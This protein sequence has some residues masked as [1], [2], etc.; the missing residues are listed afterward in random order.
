MRSDDY[1]MADFV[2]GSQAIKEARD[3]NGVELKAGDYISL[4]KES[5]SGGEIKTIL[6]NGNITVKIKNKIIQLK[7]CDC[8]KT[9]KSAYQYVPMTDIYSKLVIKE[10][11]TALLVTDFTPEYLTGLDEIEKEIKRLKELMPALTESDYKKFAALPLNKRRYIFDTLIAEQAKLTPKAKTLRELRQ[12]LEEHGG[13]NPSDADSNL[14]KPTLFLDFTTG[15]INGDNTRIGPVPT[16][17]RSTSASYVNSQGIIS[18]ANIN[19]PRFNYDPVTLKPQGLLVE[20]GRT[21]L[22][23]W[24]STISQWTATNSTFTSTTTA[25]PNGTTTGSLTAGLWARTALTP[26]LAYAGLAPATVTGN[27]AYTGSIYVQPVSGDYFAL[28]LQTSGGGTCQADVVFNLSTGSISTQPSNNTGNMTNLGASIVPAGNGW[29]RV[30]LAATM[31]AG[32]TSCQ[33]LFTFNATGNKTDGNPPDIQLSSGL[34]WGAQLEQGAGTT[35]Y[36]Q[37]PGSGSVGRGEDDVRIT[38]S[39]FT[40]FFNQSQGTFLTNFYMPNDSN[41]SSRIIFGWDNTGTLKTNGSGDQ[42]FLVDNNTSG[43]AVSPVTSSYKGKNVLTGIT[44]TSTS[45][46]ATLSGLTPGIG[47]GPITGGSGVTSPLTLLKLGGAENTGV[48][49]NSTI[50]QIAYIPRAVPAGLLQLLTTV[51]PSYLGKP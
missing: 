42:T 45:T 15:L 6:P 25:A 36:I 8:I 7:P 3:S 23:G 44:Y 10:E 2:Y 28:R 16:F 39:S 11:P 30:A 9:E 35:S 12:E 14:W 50:A 1:A 31:I 49:L 13:M 47:A 43:L 27:T 17:T 20:E 33:L 4:L 34:V 19:V 26:L 51:T 48:T 24:S 32:A 37:T 18:Y 22:L 38:G 5:K 21:N 46:T 41:L 29:F 40:S